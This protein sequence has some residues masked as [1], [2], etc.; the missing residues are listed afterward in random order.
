MAH[1]E[2]HG[3]LE[4]HLILLGVFDEYA[5][6]EDEH[7][8]QTEEESRAYTL[9][10]VLIEPPADEEEAGVAQRLVK[11]AGMAGAAYPPARR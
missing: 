1:I 5:A 7:K 3:I 2:E 6:C 10:L 8:A 11:L 9:G 4:A